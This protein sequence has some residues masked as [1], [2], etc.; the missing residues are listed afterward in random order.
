MMAD[1]FVVFFF[2]EEHSVQYGCFLDY[3]SNIN[4]ALGA[5]HADHIN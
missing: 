1:W 4:F 3:Q 5:V 2:L